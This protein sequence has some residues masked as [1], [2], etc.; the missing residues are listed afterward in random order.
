MLRATAFALAML[1]VFTAPAHATGLK[2]TQSV[3]V[4]TIITDESG[5]DTLTFVP[6]T[7]VEPGQNLRYSLAYANE[8]SEAAENVSLV[9]PVPA[10]VTYL[11]ASVSE[12]SAQVLYSADNGETFD[13]RDALM[14]G[15]A[16]MRRIANADEITH[17][18]WTF[19]TPIA[20]SESGTISYM[21]VLK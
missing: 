18:K 17:I 4:A 16:E 7:E 2:A 15:E 20:P 12:A 14:V 19:A 1:G 3:E 8:G 6:A 9:M 21:G 13:A 5:E 11:E 10:E